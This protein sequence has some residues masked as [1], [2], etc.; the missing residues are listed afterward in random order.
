MAILA[1]ACGGHSP[2]AP[3]STA[4]NAPGSGTINGA[5]ISGTVVGMAGAA[6]FQPRSGGLSVSVTGTS[7]SAPVDDSGHFLL[8]G[9]PAGHVELHFTGTGIDARLTLED[10]AE[11][12][13]VQITVT[14]SGTT[15]Q[16]GD[17]AREDDDNKVEVEG[18]VTH[19]A[20]NTLTV[21]GRS[22]LV[23][24]STTI[25]HGDT[26]LALSN[27]HVGDRIHVH[28][29]I[30]SSTSPVTATTIE[31]QQGEDTPGRGGDDGNHGSVELSGAIS[32]KSGSCPAISFTVSSTK[33]T[34]S[35]S[36]HFEDTT[37]GALVNGNR[38]E[39][40]GTKQSDGSVAAT[41]VEKED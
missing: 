37:C 26:T 4:T 15:A 28:G 33:V 27:I 32:G 6:R 13:T 35:S 10:V 38:V 14:I 17:D 29:T 39:V 16:L 21:A 40:K 11:H 8:Q 20:G 36:T 3:T 22:I 19:I 12:A 34:T 30:T 9:V 2:S 24:P 25:R 1:L 18:I 41:S 5:T 23:T 7:V 31:V